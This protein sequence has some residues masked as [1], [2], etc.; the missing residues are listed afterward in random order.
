[1]QLSGGLLRDAAFDFRTVNW[2]ESD[3]TK[4]E[5][6]ANLARCRCP[7]RETRRDSIILG[8]SSYSYKAHV[9]Y[10]CS[11]QHRESWCLCRTRA[12][13]LIGNGRTCR[14]HLDTSAQARRPRQNTSGLIPIRIESTP[15]APPLWRK[16][17]ACLGGLA[18][19]RVQISEARCLPSDDIMTQLFSVIGG[20][21]TVPSCSFGK[22]DRT[23]SL[24]ANCYSTSA[25]RTTG[26]RP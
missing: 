5:R 23:G 3:E 1:M 2:V 26:S 21:K 16:V 20:H 25:N 8:Q 24:W 14:N 19:L 18:I 10:R 17:P 11:C 9:R 15:N 13:V 6:R 22:L 4:D 12:H 7:R